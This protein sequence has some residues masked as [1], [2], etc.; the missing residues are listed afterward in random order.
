VTVALDIPDAIEPVE[1]WKGWI[2]RPDGKLMSNRGN[3]VWEPGERIEANCPNPPSIRC[4]WEVDREADGSEVEPVAYPPA[5][6]IYPAYA[7]SSVTTFT[8]APVVELKKIEPPPIFLPSAL[9][10]FYRGR[11]LRHSAPFEDCT[12]GIYLADTAGEAAGYGTVLGK[13]A[14]WG[15]VVRHSH[16]ARVQYAY[17]SEL[18]VTQEQAKII[19]DYG[20]P[21]VLTEK[22]ETVASPKKPRRERIYGGILVV[23]ALLNLGLFFASGFWLNAVGAVAVA[24]I[25]GVVL[26]RAGRYP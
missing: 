11:I 3:L 22:P 14:G 10:W 6:M 17:P 25:S 21:L 15:T 8:M 1:G 24:F 23:L 2:L 19:A 20:V 7:A 26:A 13:I 9:R 4:C 12:C 18:H 16:G 5:Q